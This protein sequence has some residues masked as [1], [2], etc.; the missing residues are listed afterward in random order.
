MFQRV[1]LEKDAGRG[2]V[3]SRL[4]SGIADDA[5]EPVT[6]TTERQEE[7]QPETQ[8]S[9][10]SEKLR[11]LNRLSSYVNVLTLMSLSL[12]LVYLGQRIEVN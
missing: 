12:H 7:V 9:V 10:L 11:T 2:R 8:T 3:T 5:G 1:K 6:A 4:T